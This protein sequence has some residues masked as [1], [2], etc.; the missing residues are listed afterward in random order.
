MN[1]QVKEKELVI[2]NKETYIKGTVGKT[3]TF[4][5]DEF[6]DEY[7]KT[8][9]FKSVSNT[10]IQLVTDNDIIVPWEVL[11]DI[12]SFK[13][14]VF[15]TRS[16]VVTPT[17]WS[18]ALIV[19]DG[20]DT[21]GESPTAPTPTEYAKIFRILEQKQDSLSEEQLS[22]ANSGITAER[23]LQI[24][25]NESE[26]S[27]IRSDLY[28]KEDKSNKVT[29]ISSS[30][31]DTKY[32]SA[33]ATYE[34][35]KSEAFYAVS[36]FQTSLENGTVKPR[37]AVN[38][39]FANMATYD[40]NGDDLMETREIAVGTQSRIETVEDK[41]P[42]QAT[43]TNKLADRDFV[44]SSINSVT[45]FYITKNA[46]GD[47][48]ETY[49][50]LSSATTFYSGGEVRVP[51]RNDYCIVRV[52]E[53]KSNA[54]TRYIYQNNQWEYQYT[55]NETALTADQ[56]AALN[57]GITSGLVALIGTALQPSALNGYATE[58]YVNNH[59]DNTKLDIANISH[60]TWT[61]TLE[62]DTTVAKEVALWTSQQ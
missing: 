17:Y 26:I 57:S 14:G 2:T 29:S 54:T 43:E 50:E 21:S 27:S 3:I 13:I 38:A 53:T 47:A 48:F 52:D 56:M 28:D 11:S 36:D 32:P 15:G 34:C 22:A 20:T 16:G 46:R 18:E 9:V 37:D 55:V 10:F 19:E 31:T 30:S 5:F 62:D 44:N 60:E 23:V 58:T 1:I 4:T 41:I 45:A 39:D 33:K 25:A 35:A 42:A 6:W 24:T 49:A 8:V 40:A 51:T 59:H 61:F 7:T 12:G